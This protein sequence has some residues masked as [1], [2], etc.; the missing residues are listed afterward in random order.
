MGW[1]TLLGLGD[2][3]CSR[4]GSQGWK[5]FIVN[6]IAHW[7]WHLWLENCT[8][9]AVPHHLS[10][11]TQSLQCRRPKWRP[12]K[13]RIAVPM[14]PIPGEGCQGEGSLSLWGEMPD[15]VETLSLEGVGNDLCRERESAVKW[16]QRRCDSWSKRGGTGPAWHGKG[17]EQQGGRKARGYCKEASL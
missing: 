5:T 16:D 9:Q 6:K 14:S 2:Y 3:R 4:S 10:W 11:S 13:S 12:P 1:E 8:F 7:M 17:G 15:G